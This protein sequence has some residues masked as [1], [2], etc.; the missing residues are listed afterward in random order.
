MAPEEP[1]PKQEPRIY[2]DPPG[3]DALGKGVR[4]ACGAVLGLVVAGEVW[5][6]CGPFG[7]I[8]TAIVLIAS[9]AVCTVGAVRH[10]DAFWETFLRRWR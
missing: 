10:G 4:A 2:P 5:F 3:P 9:V 1:P 6:R 7:G 8:G